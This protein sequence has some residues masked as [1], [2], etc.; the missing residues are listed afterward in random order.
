[1]EYI[2]KYKDLYVT[3]VKWHPIVDTILT[4]MTLGIG[5]PEI[6]DKKRA[7]IIAEKIQGDLIEI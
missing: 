1:M 5:L 3:N 4:G 6:Y 2:I 7:K